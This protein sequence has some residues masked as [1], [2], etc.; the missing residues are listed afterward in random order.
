MQEEEAAEKLKSH[1]F[2][3]KDSKKEDAEKKIREK[4]EKLD[5]DKDLEIDTEG[6]KID[7]MTAQRPPVST[8]HTDAELREFVVSCLI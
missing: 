8:I 3:E 5:V 7:T 1:K 2:P 6:E 4:G